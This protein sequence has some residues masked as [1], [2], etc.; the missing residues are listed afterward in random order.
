ML[1]TAELP[2]AGAP[3]PQGAPPAFLLTQRMHLQ[4]KTLIQ[5]VLIQS[6]F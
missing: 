5:S 3:V 2:M 6:R 4:E 1:A